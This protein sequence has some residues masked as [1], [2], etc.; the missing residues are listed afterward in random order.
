MKISK[1]IIEEAIEK[2]V[3]KENPLSGIIAGVKGVAGGIKGTFQNMGANYRL[4]N[5]GS[6]MDQFAKKSKK[7]WDINSKKAEKQ[8]D[9]MMSSKNQDVVAAAQT[10]DQQ[11]QQAD[12]QIAQTLD[13]VSNGIARTMIAAGGSS[14]QGMKQAM[15]FRMGTAGMENA[16]NSKGI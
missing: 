9:K 16:L 12:R 4:S 5:I 7:A 10:V 15:G 8:I 14:S 11:L 1:K 6:Q 3:L 13:F 2:E